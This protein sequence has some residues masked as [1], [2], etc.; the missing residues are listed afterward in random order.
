MEA[1]TVD[2]LHADLNAGLRP[3]SINIG[4]IEMTDRDLTI[5][6]SRVN[7]TRI[8]REFSLSVAELT[9]SMSQRLIRLVR[10]WYDARA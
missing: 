7:G 1:Y 5:H 4:V 6:T 10:T 8:R 2:D 9:P 3:H